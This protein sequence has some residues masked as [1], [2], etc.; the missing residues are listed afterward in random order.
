MDSERSLASYCILLAFCFDNTHIH[1]PGSVEGSISLWA[2]IALSCTL[3]SSRRRL[4]PVRFTTGLPSDRLR[5]SSAAYRS[6]PPRFTFPHPRG[7]SSIVSVALSFALHHESSTSRELVP[8]VWC[9]DFPSGTYW[10]HI[11][12]IESIGAGHYRMWATAIISII[13]INTR[14]YNIIKMLCV[15]IFIIVDPCNRVR[16]SVYLRRNLYHLIYHPY[17]CYQKIYHQ[18]IY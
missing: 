15:I 1:K 3:R 7:M 4:H 16:V 18:K 10:N 13:S 9:Q 2:L 11:I 17:G 6:S 14:K 5:K 12:F 8:C